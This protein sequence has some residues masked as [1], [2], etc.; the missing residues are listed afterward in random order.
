MERLLSVLS[1]ESGQGLAEYSLI[2]SLVALAALSAVILLNES[3]FDLYET[4]KED[5]IKAL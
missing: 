2:L 4:I 1:D 5:V 3:V